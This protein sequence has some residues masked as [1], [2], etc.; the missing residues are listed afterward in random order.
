MYE[1]LVSII[2][3]LSFLKLIII[4][5]NFKKILLNKD[6]LCVSFLNH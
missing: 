1:L 3:F 4:Y 2:L 5:V 6:D